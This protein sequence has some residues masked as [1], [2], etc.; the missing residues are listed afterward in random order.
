MKNRIENFSGAL[1]KSPT[2]RD[3]SVK[4]RFLFR[5]R[6][7]I[8]SIMP[9][10]YLL[11]GMGLFGFFVLYPLFK[12]MYY[13]FFD[14]SL[15]ANTREFIGLNNY[16]AVLKDDIFIMALKNNLLYLVWNVVIEVGFGAIIAYFLSTKG[17]KGVK[18]FRTVYLIPQVIPIIGVGVLFRL[19]FNKQF[20]LVN[21][22][23]KIIGLESFTKG[24]LGI[25]PEA[26]FAIFICSVWVYL[27]YT[28]LLLNA[29]MQ[30]IP[31][32]I[33]EAAEIDGVSYFTKFTKITIPL[34]KEVLSFVIG[35]T[36]FGSFVQFGLFFMITKGNPS[37]KTEVVATWMIKNGIYKDYSS[38]M[39]LIIRFIRGFY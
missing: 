26:L 7:I 30:R 5:I 27:G 25:Y 34:I 37:H 14:I 2:E 1:P 6:K 15:L 13:S 23:L 24:W 4:Y 17:I 3:N 31:D 36:I 33:Y 16:I 19:M 12:G 18:I 21:S 10:L 9:Y 20:G 22:L 8:S 38:K 28:T 11:P 32:E 35:M 39:T 29:A